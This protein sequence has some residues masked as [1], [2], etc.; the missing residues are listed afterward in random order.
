MRQLWID[1]EHMQQR[2]V[3][4]MVD[5]FWSGGVHAKSDATVWR[6]WDPDVQLVLRVVCVRLPLGVHVQR[7]HLSTEHNGKSYG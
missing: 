7:E 5:M 4:V 6:Q 1:D 2:D 3:V